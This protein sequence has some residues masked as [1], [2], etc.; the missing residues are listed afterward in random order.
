MGIWGFSFSITLDCQGEQRTLAW[1]GE[2]SKTQATCIM[3]R[4][5]DVAEQAENEVLQ[6]CFEVK[7][8]CVTLL[9]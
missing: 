6:K 4:I 2:W 7:C 3:E 1:L 8:M 9:L 5:C